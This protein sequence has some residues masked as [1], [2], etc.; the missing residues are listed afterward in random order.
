MTNRFSA[1]YRGFMYHRLLKLI[2]NH[3]HDLNNVRWRSTKLFGTIK[4]KA[5]ML[6]TE[7][8]IIQR[9]KRNLILK[10]IQLYRSQY[11]Y[12]QSYSNVCKIQYPIFK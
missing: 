2:I 12:A 10:I 1:K 5:Y 11:T 6:V 8:R 9:A 3:N 4:I 7:M